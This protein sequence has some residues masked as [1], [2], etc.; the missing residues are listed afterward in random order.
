MSDAR[1]TLY[2]A[3]SNLLFLIIDF[4]FFARCVLYIYTLQ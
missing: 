4:I 2:T 1:R 3:T